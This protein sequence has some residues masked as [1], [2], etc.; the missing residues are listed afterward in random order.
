[1]PFPLRDRHSDQGDHI[2]GCAPALEYD[3]ISL[4]HKGMDSRTR[5][6][7]LTAKKCGTDGRL[8][9]GIDASTFHK[10]DKPTETSLDLAQNACRGAIPSGT[11][12]FTDTSSRTDN[13]SPDR[14][15]CLRSAGERCEI[16]ASVRG[17]AAKQGISR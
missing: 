9:W 14:L 8:Q 2:D 3:S 15:P 1:M 11:E 12:A 5:C 10:I 13:G 6:E 16:C 4:H 7:R 17:G